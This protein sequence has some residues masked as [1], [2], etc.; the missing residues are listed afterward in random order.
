MALSPSAA[1]DISSIKQL[2][3]NPDIEL[4]IIPNPEP[5]PLT[6]TAKLILVI[7]ILK[8][9][10]T[11]WSLCWGIG[12]A[13]YYFNRIQ[14]DYYPLVF[15]PDDNSDNHRYALVASNISYYVSQQDDPDNDPKLY[16]KNASMKSCRIYKFDQSSVLLSKLDSNSLNIIED[17]Q[18]T[19]S[20][21]HHNDTTFFRFIFVVEI[22]LVVLSGI[23]YIITLAKDVVTYQEKSRKFRG[24]PPIDQANPATNPNEPR[25]C[26]TIFKNAYFFIKRFLFLLI[27]DVGFINI[28]NTKMKTCLTNIPPK[29]DILAGFIGQKNLNTSDVDDYNLKIGTTQ[30]W[31]N[32]IAFCAIIYLACKLIAAIYYSIARICHKE[33]ASER[34]WR[35]IVGGITEIIELGLLLF[36]SAMLII[37]RLFY[38]NWNQK[39]DAFSVSAKEIVTII[40]SLFFCCSK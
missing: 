15:H 19:S 5:R 16:Y 13:I 18:R 35:K 9:A 38:L 34:L 40:S 6:K 25:S 39:G 27:I 37:W 26:W 10:L 8:M 12:N 7:L 21:K 30:V 3:D 17:H 36:L 1:S 4:N 31:M 14:K 29:L 24:L 22:I 28:Y 33:T 32:M 23:A 20:P 11:I 2:N